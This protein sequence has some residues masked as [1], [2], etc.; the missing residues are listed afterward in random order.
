MFENVH[1]PEPPPYV[2]CSGGASSRCAVI[3]ALFRAPGGRERLAYEG[4]L[5]LRSY[6][7]L[8]STTVLFLSMVIFAARPRSEI[9]MFFSWMSRPSVIALPP[10]RM[11]MPCKIG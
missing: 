2:H 11:A 4:I 5:I 9:R 6:A 10:V 7:A 8:T 1:V 3:V